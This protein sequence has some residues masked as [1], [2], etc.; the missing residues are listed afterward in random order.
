MCMYLYRV[1][2][3]GAGRACA[4]MVLVVFL[5]RVRGATEE[6]IPEP[7]VVDDEFVDHGNRR[8]RAYSF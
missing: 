6:K 1:Y 3:T 4:F 8:A 7:I 2:G 5:R